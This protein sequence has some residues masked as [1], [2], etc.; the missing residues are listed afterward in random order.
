MVPRRDGNSVTAVAA[1]ILT[2]RRSERLRDDKLPC[3]VVPLKRTAYFQQLAEQALGVC[4]AG[5]ASRFVLLGWLIAFS[6]P[7]AVVRA[8]AERSPCPTRFRCSA[9]RLTPRPA[10]S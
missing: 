5:S 1:L 2:H 3:L 10:S 9:D 7:S 4:P 6:L 8:R